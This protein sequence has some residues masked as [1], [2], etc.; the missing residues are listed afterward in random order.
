VK[1]FTFLL[2][3]L[4]LKSRRLLVYACKFFDSLMQRI[5]LDLEKHLHISRVLKGRKP[6]FKI[7]GSSESVVAQK[8]LIFIFVRFIISPEKNPRKSVS[9]LREEIR[10]FKLLKHIKLLVTDCSHPFYQ[11]FPMLTWILI[12]SRSIMTTV[13]SVFYLQVGWLLTI[14]VVRHSVDLNVHHVNMSSPISVQHVEEPTGEPLPYI[15]LLEL[16]SG[17]CADDQVNASV[18]IFVALMKTS[19]F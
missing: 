5:G 13:H 1:F 10:D 6:L 9:I 11:N 19:M 12:V 15:H 14:V 18:A 3:F 17:G 4:Y 2:N 16:M 7:L 8:R